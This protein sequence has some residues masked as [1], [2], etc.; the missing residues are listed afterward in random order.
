MNDPGSSRIIY[1]T[2]NTLC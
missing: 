1:L 2:N